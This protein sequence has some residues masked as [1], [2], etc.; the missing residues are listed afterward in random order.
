M[1]IHDL[2][3]AIIIV[4]VVILAAAFSSNVL[5][6]VQKGQCNDAIAG[7]GYDSTTGTCF[8]NSTT[9]ASNV[10]GFGLTTLINLTQ[11]MP[12]VGLIIIVAVIIGILVTSFIVYQS[13]QQ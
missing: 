11:Q 10:T 1:N 6:S 9:I 12:N 4:V 8:T 2:L 13:R 3:P 5:Q 7:G